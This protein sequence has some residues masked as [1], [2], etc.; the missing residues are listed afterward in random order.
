L[1][2]VRDDPPFRVLRTVGLI[3]RKGLGTG[4]R[5]VF[6][7][8]LTWLPI[9]IWDALVR[10]AAS[11]AGG[12]PLLQHFSVHVRCLLAIPLLILA[13]GLAHKTTTRLLPW[14]VKSGVVPEEKRPRL[15]DVV[16]GVARLRNAIAPWIVIAGLVVA[17]TAIQPVL[18]NADDLSWANE[19][20]GSGAAHLGFGGWWFLF[21]A[22]P[23]YIVLL[24]AWLWRLVLL[25]K[26]FRGIAKLGLDLVPT[27]PDRVG[28]LGFVE[29]FATIFG[30]VAFALSVVLASHWAHQVVYH[31]L[32][33][34]SL[35]AP[36]VAF[37]VVVLVVFLF[38]FV[39]FVGPLA[40]AKKRA[41]LEYGALVGEHGDLVRKRWIL[42]ETIA[43]DGLL[44]APEIGPVADTVSL[45]EAVEKMRPFPIG[46]R[47]LIAV[48]LPAL[49]PIVLVIAIKVPVREILGKLLKGVV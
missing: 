12:E 41:E 27:H 32:P 45:Y 15:E 7:A 48:A 25:T 30:P 29:R 20:S 10:P 38:P 33:V 16:H 2:L 11:A 36:A 9:A 46:K 28:G 35:K 42:K 49:I 1:S 14:F 3:P 19:A 43:D 8:L 4:R 26:L 13:Q 6:F 40:A 37:L 31:D 23:I 5:A 18:Q 34:Q 24:L 17:W 21:V 44:H 47:A 22:R 39:A